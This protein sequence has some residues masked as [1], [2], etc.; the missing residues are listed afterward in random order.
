MVDERGVPT[1][2][3]YKPLPLMTAYGNDCS[4]Y[5]NAFDYYR[6]LITLPLHTRLTDED[7]GFIIDVLKEV[8]PQFM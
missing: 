2:V 8:I 5:P 7:V 1:N 4:D 6:N 3:H